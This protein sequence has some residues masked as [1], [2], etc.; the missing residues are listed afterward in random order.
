ML[1]TVNHFWA[2]QVDAVA[3]KGFDRRPIGDFHMML[4]QH[5]PQNAGMAFDQDMIVKQDR[6]AA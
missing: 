4:N 6:A 2:T 5:V 3:I 1:F